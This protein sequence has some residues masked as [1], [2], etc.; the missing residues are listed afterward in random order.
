MPALLAVAAAAALAAASGPSRSLPYESIRDPVVTGVA[1]AAWLLSHV[2]ED[3]LAPSACRWCDP[4]AFD[5]AARDRLRW[6]DPAAAGIASDVLAYGGVPL[7]GLG[8]DF[9]VSGRDAKVAG[10]DA[11]IAAETLALA[12]LFGQAVKVVVARER[13]GA[14]ARDG[15]R[16]S[17][18]EHASFYSGHT[19]S[20]FAVA[21][22]LATCASLRGDREAWVLWAAGLPLAAATGYLRMAADRHYLSDVLAGAGAGALFGI[23][24]P[25]LLH[26][27]GAPSPPPAGTARFPML[28][29][30]GRF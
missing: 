3:R 2:F 26:S 23:L 28:T 1:G 29:F 22:S 8:V 14:R 17:S 16:G 11:L 10:T 25:R 5:A 30:G 7:L 24:V 6:A 18:D 13:P 20:A 4:P 9:F 19:S 27:P 15:T 21:V 12:G